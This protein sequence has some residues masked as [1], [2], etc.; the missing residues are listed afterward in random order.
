MWPQGRGFYFGVRKRQH[1]LFCG[2]GAVV[3]CC[4]LLLAPG[5]DS[6]DST[7]SVTGQLVS[8]EHLGDVS[9]EILSPLLAA[10]GVEASLELRYRVAVY[11]IQY[12]TVDQDGRTVEASA[13]LYIPI[14]APA[15][16]FA[17]TQ[18]GTQTL[19]QNVASQVPILYG[20]DAFILAAEGYVACSPDYLG[21]GS[22][23]QMHPYLYAATSAATVIDAIRAGV[24]FCDERS[25]GLNGSLFL[26]GYSQGGYVT[27]AAQRAIEAGADVGLSLS[28]VA[29]LSGPYDLIGIVDQ[30]LR[31][32]ADDDVVLAAF[33]V[34]AYNGIYGWNRLA[35][36]FQSP[37]DGR[38][39]ALF[40]GTH[41][42]SAVR[43]ALPPTIGGLL[44]SDF[45]GRYLRGEEPD[46][47]AAI[48][49]NT[50]LDWT[51]QA[52]LRLVH[53]RADTTVPYANAVTAFETFTRRGAPH[54]ELVT[55]EGLGHESTIAVAI[56]PTLAW[57]RSQL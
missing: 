48:A 20:V 43:A 3:L 34:T 28:A 15:A 12:T 26:V 10:A 17:S 44:N 39:S 37:F 11:H 29:S 45:V 40:D 53:G 49:E 41:S 2:V 1:P 19:R 4:L 13:A 54:V 52:P 9:P 8:A 46:V 7:T 25:I 30:M 22:S 57:F 38:V 24:R 16:P 27:L 31:D 33:F 42:F 14:G 55:M 36:L 47:R 23:L 32:P 50:L 5:C 35:D 6:G 51:P 18:H 56:G 21:Y